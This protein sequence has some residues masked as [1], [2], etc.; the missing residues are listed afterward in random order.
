[1]SP[2]S[3]SQGHHSPQVGFRVQHPEKQSCDAPSSTRLS[4]LAHLVLNCSP[5]RTAAPVQGRTQSFPT[6]KGPR[7]G[8]SISQG[9][10][11]PQDGYRVQHSVKQS[12][13]KPSTRLSSLTHLPLYCSLVDYLNPLMECIYYYRKYIPSNRS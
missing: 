1:M 5:G 12:P 13:V 10:H 7:A 4:T 8:P 9:H 3:H 2:C 11:S 6:Y